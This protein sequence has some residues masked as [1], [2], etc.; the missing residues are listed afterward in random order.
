MKLG[1]LANRCCKYAYMEVQLCLRP[2]LCSAFINTES[3]TD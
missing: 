2:G 3:K 1:S